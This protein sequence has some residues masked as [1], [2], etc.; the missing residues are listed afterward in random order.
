LE[1]ADATS[2]PDLISVMA[3]AALHEDAPTAPP[4]EENNARIYRSNEPLTPQEEE[5]AR[6]AEIL[7]LM[8][9]GTLKHVSREELTELEYAKRLY[10]R[11]FTQ[12][13]RDGRPKGRTVAGTGSR[14][15]DRTD[16]IKGQNSGSYS[17][18]VSTPAVFMTCAIA[19]HIRGS[20]T[21]A[22]RADHRFR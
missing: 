10:T 16:L 8:Q 19:A 11:L 15:Q 12:R 9:Y 13:K 7:T 1:E 6:R 17:P 18:T 4:L 3:W 14:A 20:M 5:D 2:T 22:Q 21:L